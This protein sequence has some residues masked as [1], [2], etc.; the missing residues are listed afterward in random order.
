MIKFK[1]KLDLLKILNIIFILV[2]V[3]VMI[4]PILN[5]I[6][7][8]FSTNMDSMRPGITLWPK[9]FSVEGYKT[10]IRKLNIWRPFLVSVFVTILGT[11]FHVMLSAFAAYS[12]IQ[13]D[14]LYKKILTMIIIVSMMVPSQAI[15]VPQYIVFKQ[16]GLMNS[17][18]ALI[19]SGLVSGFSILLLSNYFKT[20]PYALY[21]SAV[22]DGAGHFTILKNI[23]FPIAKPGLMTV[24]LFEFVS[25]WNDFTSALL[26]INNPKLYTL[27]L[28]LRSVLTS[29]D[30]TSTAN[31]LTNNAKMA[32]I[33]ISLIPLLLI[34]P[35]VQKY[36]IKGVNLGAIKE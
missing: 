4:L 11:F 25:R 20:V 10:I 17:L 34:Y 15:M 32:G 29:D 5:S 1:N 21:E 31:L 27:Q 19:I 36:F 3:S 24:T 33:V 14:L 28:A 13:K 7:V 35:F 6:A 2:L 23:Y 18:N 8:S 9:K 22:I 16:L 26:Y 30:A 12:L